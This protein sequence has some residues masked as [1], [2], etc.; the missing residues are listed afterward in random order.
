MVGLLAGCSSEPKLYRVSGTVLVQGKSV[1]KGLIFFDPVKEGS[2][3]FANI[4]DGKFDTAKAG[5]GVLAGEYT[6]RIN[7]FDGK[8]GNEAPF[9][10][11][12]LPEYQE[13]RKLPNSDS[14][15]QFDL[16]KK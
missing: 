8:A 1:P 12:M 10:Q 4:E 5:K 13:T 3:G 7:A 15:I 2:Q 14:E 9:G 16:K 11:P 6:I